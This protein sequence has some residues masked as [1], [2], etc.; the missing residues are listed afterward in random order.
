M[1][2]SSSLINKFIR[3]QKKP[4]VRHKVLSPLLMKP[5]PNLPGNVITSPK[6]TIDPSV[7]FGCPAPIC[8]T[9]SCFTI[10]VAYIQTTRTAIVVIQ[11]NMK[12]AV[13]NTVVEIVFL[14]KPAV[15][16]KIP[17]A[18]TYTTECVGSR[19]NTEQQKHGKDQ[20]VSHFLDS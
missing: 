19:C 6:F 18:Q 15:A 9:H 11:G 20:L 3:F 17:R 12:S 2:K 10:P 13:R 8:P 4:K 16:F 5:S 7:N 14:P 1:S